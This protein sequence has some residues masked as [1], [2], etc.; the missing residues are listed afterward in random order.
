MP[1]PPMNLKILLPFGIFADE[2]G[3]LR[4]VAEGRAGSFGLLPHRLDCVAALAPGIL[5]YET[6]MKGEVFAAVDEGV[7]VKTG[8]DVVVSVRNAIVGKD[9]AHLRKTVE[10]EFLSLDEKEKNV[11]SVVAKMESSLIR[12]L[13]E[14]QR[15]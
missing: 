7:L 15:E 8:A 6:K 5:I 10:Q 4:I 11:R 14:Y 2:T 1:L 3:V 13:A 9:L 12:G